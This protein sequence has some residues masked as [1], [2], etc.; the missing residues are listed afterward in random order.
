MLV[1]F[2]IEVSGF[3]NREDLPEI[4]RVNN[5]GAQDGLFGFYRLG[6]PE[7]VVTIHQPPAKTKIPLPGNRRPDSN[8]YLFRCHRN[9]GGRSLGNNPLRCRRNPCKAASH[10]PGIDRSL[11]RVRSFHQPINLRYCQPYDLH[12]LRHHCIT[13]PF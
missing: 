4:L 12:N 6:K 10:L 8:S 3:Q 13:E 5:D 11:L 2:T 1:F 7:C 9:S